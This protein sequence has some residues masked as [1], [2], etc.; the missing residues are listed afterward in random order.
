MDLRQ[1]NEKE[2]KVQAAN[3][4]ALMELYCAGKL[5]L[6]VGQVFPLSDYTKAL[7]AARSGEILGRIVIAMR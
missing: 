3:V 5:K 7:R 1:F 6:P 4:A 2:P